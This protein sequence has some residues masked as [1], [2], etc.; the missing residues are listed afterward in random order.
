MNVNAEKVIVVLVVASFALTSMS[1]LIT[2]GNPL[3]REEAIEI[4]RNS[5]LVQRFWENADRYMLEVNYQNQTDVWHITWYIHPMDAVS[6]FAYVVSQS[7]DGETGEIL[8][9]G[10]A[11]IR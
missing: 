2:A 5:Q 10:A 9:E 7:I 11:S 8:D 1:T 4:S 6:A 3:T